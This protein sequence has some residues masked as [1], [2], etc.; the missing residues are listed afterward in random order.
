MGLENKKYNDMV[1]YLKENVDVLDELVSE[2]NSWDGSLD[3]YKWYEHDE[4]FYDDFFNDKQEIARAV[5]Y[6]SN[7]NYTDE[8]VKF[9]AYGNLQTCCEYEKEQD[10]KDGVEEILDNWLEL[11]GD[12]DVD[13]S[14][15][16]FKE[17]VRTFYDEENDKNE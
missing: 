8:Y 7:Y 3:D 14:D 5:Y 6:A 17:L 16:D 13:V 9:N 4:Y 15:D 10:L 12:D 11:Y 1:E 2:C